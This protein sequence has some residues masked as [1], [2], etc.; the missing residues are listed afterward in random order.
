MLRRIS[1]PHQKTC[2]STLN[3]ATSK[4]KFIVLE[5]LKLTGKVSAAVPGWYGGC[6]EKRGLGGWGGGVGR[7]SPEGA[8]N[9]LLFCLFCCEKE[10]EGPVAVPHSRMSVQ[11]LPACLTAFLLGFQ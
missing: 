4:I 9:S 1:F 8:W 3:V 10:P 5:N 11:V 2:I 7:Q 6:E